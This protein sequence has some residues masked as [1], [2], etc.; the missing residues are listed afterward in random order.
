MQ[1]FH[2]PTYPPCGKTRVHH[3]VVRCI[4]VTTMAVHVQV[5]AYADYLGMDLEADPELV[6]IAKYA[7]DAVLPSDWSANF[8]ADGEEYFQ[9]VVTGVKQYEHPLDEAYFEFYKSLKAKKE[10]R[11]GALSGA[12]I[13]DA[14]M[15]AA[16]LS[17]Q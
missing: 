14:K 12:D 3:Q 10:A 4:T 11:Q 16:S 8:D 5:R 2:D 17:M 15:R 6:F 13:A 1:T 7:M 9:N